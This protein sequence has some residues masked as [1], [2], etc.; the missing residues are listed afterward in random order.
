MPFSAIKERDSALPSGDRANMPPSPPR[1]ALNGI[2][3]SAP[4]SYMPNNVAATG[5]SESESRKKELEDEALYS[6]PSALKHKSSA[7][8]PVIPLSPDPFGRHASTPEPPT[9]QVSGAQWDTRT[10]GK[11]ER[12]EDM[13][14]MQQFAQSGPPVQGRARSNTAATNTSRFS[15]DSLKAEPEPAPV[16]SKTSNRATLISVKTIKKLW[17][18]SSKAAV[19]SPRAETPPAVPPTPTT[20]TPSPFAG[21]GPTGAPQRPER[22]PQDQ[23]YL[24]PGVGGLAPQPQEMYAGRR[25]LEQPNGGNM[26]NMGRSA[27]PPSPHL[28]SQDQLFPAGRRS[29]DRSQNGPP[30]TGAVG[31]LSPQPMPVGAPPPP[32]RPSLDQMQ[33]QGASRLSLEQQG[34]R[35]SQ[36]QQQ[37]MPPPRRSLEQF[38]P[39]QQ[40]QQQ[41]QYLPPQQQQYAPPQQQYVPPPPPQQYA[42]P[43]QQQQQ[44]YLPQQQLNIPVF[45]GRN[46]HPGPIIT[47][48][49]QASKSASSLDRLHFDQES[50]YP[51]HRAAPS[52]QRSPRAPSP[53]SLPAIPEGEDQQPDARKSI[54][55]WKSAAST[56]SASSTQSQAQSERARASLDRSSTNSSGRGVGGGSG[57]SHNGR[58][59]SV[60]NPYGSTRTSMTT[61][62]LPPSPHIPTQFF[63]KPGGGPGAGAGGLDHRTASQRSRLTTSS[64]DSKYSPPKRQI[65]LG[66]RSV[67]PQRSMASSR[68]S[69]GSRPSFDASQFEFVSPKGG[70]LSYPF[71][72]I[73]QQ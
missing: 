24:P 56:S 12:D 70:T 59:P 34:R 13:V 35:P 46:P 31:R 9:V 7:D 32:G 18:K 38:A 50:P 27:I 52:V 51:T 54:L 3:T 33:V 45:P 11:G 10:I 58:R 47:P 65:S 16:A 17:R 21:A 41:Q 5:L 66:G 28:P 40:Q 64:T 39:P 57:S 25:S 37:Y 1:L 49:M 15:A 6:A 22:P 55:R 44:Q 26:G 2:S 68:D 23:L 19:A 62:E 71:N 53:T 42:H 48:Y 67:S 4:K 43:Q 30:V 63:V 60:T 8:L 29:L 36:E 72:T 61:P 73:D 20:A 69:Q 14:S